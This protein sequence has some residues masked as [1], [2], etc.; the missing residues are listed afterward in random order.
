M[1]RVLLIGAALIIAFTASA[2]ETKSVDQNEKNTSEISTRLEKSEKRL[3]VL[4]K[5]RQYVKFSGFIQ[6]EYDWIDNSADKGKTG[7]SSFYIRRA[8]L[9]VSGDLY[10]G[11]KG[12]KID[13]RLYLDI[14]RVKLP[15][16]NP[17]LDMY[18]RYQPCKEFGIQFGQFKNPIT[19]EAS[20]SPAQYDF[21]DFSYVVSNLA[22]MGANDLTGYNATARDAGFQLFGGF[23]HRDGYSII[24]Y[25]VGVLNGNG[26]NAKDDNKS[27][28]V[29]G[30]LTLNVNKELALTTYYQWGEANLS[31]LSAERY[32][33]YGWNGSAEYVMFQRVGCGLKYDAKRAFIRGEYIT[34]LTG[35]LISEGAYLSGGYRHHFQKKNAGMMWVCGMVDYFCR[36]CAYNTERDTEYGPIDMRYSLCLGYAPIKYFHIQLAYSLEHRIDH[37]LGQTAN[38]CGWTRQ[39]PFGNAIKLMATASF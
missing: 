20:I 17:I 32:A 4:E 19:F 37:D 7:T 1:R 5:V 22:K 27:K 28:D 30:R 36:S 10:R 38:C 3:A 18:V 25:N 24:N 31:G 39:T 11:A 9:M 14:A 33:E 26:I 23:L 13:Y 6:G 34:G 29:F 15:N 2:Q 12:A 8:R 35:N 16:P 21:I